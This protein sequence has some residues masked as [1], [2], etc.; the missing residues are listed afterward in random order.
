MGTKMLFAGQQMEAP[1]N[2]TEETILA[3]EAAV[4]Q[5]FPYL[6]GSIPCGTVASVSLA[7]AAQASP[8]QPAHAPAKPAEA[9]DAAL[10]SDEPAAP[11]VPEDAAAATAAS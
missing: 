5:P 9:A 6:W 7:V 3:V 1:A 2:A 4:V 11:A 10:P 8:A